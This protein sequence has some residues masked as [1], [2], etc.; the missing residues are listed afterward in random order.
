MHESLEPNSNVTARRDLHL[1]NDRAPM[2]LTAEGMHIH[3]S[4]QK[5]N[6]ACSMDDSRE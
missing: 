5:E 3:E 1:K 4:E 2:R 6:A